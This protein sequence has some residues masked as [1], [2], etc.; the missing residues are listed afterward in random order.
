[1]GM[2]ARRVTRTGEMT[3]DPKPGFFCAARASPIHTPD[4]S[5]RAGKTTGVLNSGS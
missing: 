4:N 3:P 2:D 1:M 5:A